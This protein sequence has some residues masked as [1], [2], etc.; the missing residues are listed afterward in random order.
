MMTSG[1][2]VGALVVLAVLATWK[3]GV[4]GGV[5]TTAIGLLCLAVMLPLL[6]EVVAV[7][8]TGVH[9]K[10]NN[11]GSAIEGRRARRDNP[12]APARLFEGVV[13]AA[14]VAFIWGAIYAH[15]SG[16]VMHD[17][18][19][20]VLLLHALP[21]MWINSSMFVHLY[22]AATTSPGLPPRSTASAA[23][24]LQRCNR[25]DALQFP[26][27][28]HCKTCK[29]CCLGMDHHCPFTANCVGKDNYRHFFAFVLWAW[30]VSER[31]ALDQTPG[32]TP[33]QTSVSGQRCLVPRG[34]RK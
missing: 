28:H 11:S 25:C 2:G 26:G 33:G 32:Q 10:K 31:T 5:Q 1:G 14:V 22:M 29:R 15:W 23:G 19:Y 27:T 21:S 3:A 24:V 20:E 17:N 4:F 12:P 9:N 8:T 7:V 30:M 6:S 16:L 34:S 18:V 13:V